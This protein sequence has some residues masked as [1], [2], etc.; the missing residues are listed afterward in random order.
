[1]NGSGLEALGDD[2][3]GGR[4]RA[5]G[6]ELEHVVGGLGLDHHDRDVGVVALTRGDPPRDDHVEHGAGELLDGRGT[7]PTGRPCSRRWG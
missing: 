2:L 3:L 4:L 5:T 1:M 7:R 6:D